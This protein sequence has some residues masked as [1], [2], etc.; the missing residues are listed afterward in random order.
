MQTKEFSRINQQSFQAVILAKQ[1]LFLVCFQKNSSK[2]G[3]ANS[4]LISENPGYF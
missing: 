2:T 4:K 1:L 3:R